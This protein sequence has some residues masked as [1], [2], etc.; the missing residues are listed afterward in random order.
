MSLPGEKEAIYFQTEASQSA[1][2]AR[3]CL[4]SAEHSR[5]PERW[6]SLAR[7]WQKDS[8]AF[9]AFARWTMEIPE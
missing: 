7:E 6:L 2:Q 9:S 3:A 4:E 5:F 8:A 1:E